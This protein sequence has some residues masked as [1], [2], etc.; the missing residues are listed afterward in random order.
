M[1]EVDSQPCTCLCAEW[2]NEKNRT[3]GGKCSRWPYTDSRLSSRWIFVIMG[4]MGVPSHHWY[5][6]S[7]PLF[8]YFIHRIDLMS[9]L[10]YVMCLNQD[11][12]ELRFPQESLGCQSLLSISVRTPFPTG[13]NCR[14]GCGSTFNN[15]KYEKDPNYYRI[16][17]LKYFS[18][19]VN[20]FYQRKLKLTIYF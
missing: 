7:W 5:S 15:H 14:F 17:F 6:D 10:V 2:I 9:N 11:L 16:Y 12:F 8:S 19:N 1:L 4:K 18:I 13:K 3:I 20:N